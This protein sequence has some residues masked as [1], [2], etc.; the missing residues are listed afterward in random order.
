MCALSYK[1]KVVALSFQ[2]LPAPSYHINTQVGFTTYDAL[3]GMY[4]LHPGFG[5]GVGRIGQSCVPQEVD[6]ITWEFQQH[7]LLKS[8]D[9]QGVATH[10]HSSLHGRQSW[11]AEGSKA[12]AMSLKGK[13]GGTIHQSVVQP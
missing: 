7:C 9:L 12:Y 1:C 5:L 3:R 11:V 4:V 6:H 13:S 2:V 8:K 10:A